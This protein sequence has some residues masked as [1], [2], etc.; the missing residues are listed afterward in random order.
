M[1]R[2]QAIR[3]ERCLRASTDSE[4]QLMN[5]NNM[6]TLMKDSGTGL[7]SQI[8]WRKKGE[9]LGIYKNTYKS[10]EF[11]TLSGRLKTQGGCLIR[12][13]V[14]YH[15]APA[16]KTSTRR[17]CAEHVRT[18]EHKPPCARGYENR[19]RKSKAQT[20]GNDNTNDT[21]KEIT[22]VQS[23]KHKLNPNT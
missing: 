16:N 4:Q 22:K 12:S 11:G 18:R 7:A 19:N 20:W 2:K 10:S 13:M 1:T 6:P 23:A 21:L 3:S 9:R 17:T 8:I 5:E 15:E 14:L